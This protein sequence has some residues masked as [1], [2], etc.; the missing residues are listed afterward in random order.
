[1][2]YS[3]IDDEEKQLKLQLA[4][5]AFDMYIHAFSRHCDNKEILAK[6]Y[7]DLDSAQKF[8][9][10]QCAWS[11]KD[12]IK[13]KKLEFERVLKQNEDVGYMTY[14][15]VKNIMKLHQGLV[16]YKKFPDAVKTEYRE[17]ATRIRTKL[18]EDEFGE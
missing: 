4:Q 11:L 12:L 16:T 9:W 2:T 5:F 10:E 17:L 13:V 6:S 1:M 15:G 3:D 14:S 7:D 8:A 18:E